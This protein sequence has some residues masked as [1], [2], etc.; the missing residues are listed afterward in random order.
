MLKFR[1]MYADAGARQA[2]L[3]AENEAEGAL[4]KIR[5][6]PRV[7][8]V[9]RA[10]RRFSLDEIPQVLN[11][12]RGEMSLV[13]PRPTLQVQVAQYSERQR[14]RLAVEPGITGWAQVKGRA[15]LPWHER[16]ELDLWYIEHWSL[17]LDLRILASTAVLLVTG[18]GLYR[19]PTGGWRPPE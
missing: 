19:G 14:G 7:T 9:G 18:R 10:L 16:I 3:E 1:T 8:R 17:R 2:E 6:D 15:A 5:D 11:V 4:F 12:L 13:G